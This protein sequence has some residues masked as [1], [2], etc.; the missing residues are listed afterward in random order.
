MNFEV[1]FGLE[2]P[3]RVCAG[4]YKQHGCVWVYVGVSK[5]Q[6]C[7]GVYGCIAM[8]VSAYGYDMSKYTAFAKIRTR[9]MSRGEKRW[10]ARRGVAWRGMAWRVFAW[11]GNMYIHIYIYIYI[12]I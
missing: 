3:V 5:R 6:A 10:P 1:N 11:H 4:A 12:Y 9:E 8:C 7:E 2:I